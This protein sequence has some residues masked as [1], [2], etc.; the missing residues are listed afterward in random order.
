[1]VAAEIYTSYAT[2][3]RTQLISSRSDTIFLA[4]QGE[5]SGGTIIKQLRDL[6]YEDTIYSEVVPTQPEALGIAGDAATGLKVI[7]PNPDLQ[8]Q[9]GKDFL[10]NYEAHFGTVA[11]LPWFQGSAYDD[12]YIAAECLSRTGTTGIPPGSVIASTT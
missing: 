4:A 6:G 1:M 3:F 12:V 2:D 8:T 11:T 9:I 5:F 7:V 10:V